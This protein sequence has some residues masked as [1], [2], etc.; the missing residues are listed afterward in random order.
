MQPYRYIN[1]DDRRE[2]YIRVETARLD[3]STV[4]TFCR[5]L[6][7]VWAPDTEVVKLDFAGVRFI[8]SSGVGALLGIHKRLRESSEPIIILNPNPAVVSVL[9]LLRLQRV[10]SIQQE[11]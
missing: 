5:E 1:D 8:D 2:L 6:D 7:R 11:D 9:E 10:F 4:D 3:A